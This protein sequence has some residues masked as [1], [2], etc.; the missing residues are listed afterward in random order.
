MSSWY[1]LK[2]ESPDKKYKI[3]LT[4]AD[5]GYSY[6]NNASTKYNIFGGSNPSSGVETN[7]SYTDAYHPTITT[8][9][10]GKKFTQ[11]T[12]VQIKWTSR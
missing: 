1:L 11:I 4:Y 2:V 6:L 3:N 9:I 5:E 10:T 12:L 7:G 8:Y